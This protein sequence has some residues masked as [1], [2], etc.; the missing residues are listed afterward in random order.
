MKTEVWWDK[1]E[2]GREE[3]E[4]DNTCVVKHNPPHVVVGVH[5]EPSPQGRKSPRL[6][7]CVDVDGALVMVGTEAKSEGISAASEAMKRRRVCILLSLF[8]LLSRG[9]KSRYEGASVQV[10]VDFKR[11]D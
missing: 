10:L 6:Q 3:R 7:S 2:N 8:S 4:G 9:S 5:A 1:E 11:E